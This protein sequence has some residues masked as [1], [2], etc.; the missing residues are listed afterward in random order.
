MQDDDPQILEFI[1]RLGAPVYITGFDASL[2]TCMDI[3]LTLDKITDV[4]N[5]L[6]DAGEAIFWELNYSFRSHGFNCRS[7]FIYTT[8]VSPATD[9]FDFPDLLDK[10]EKIP[11]LQD[12]CCAGVM[13]SPTVSTSWNH[14]T[15]PQSWH[16]VDF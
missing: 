13:D 15:S 1:D 6:P 2:Y 4:H 7:D 16:L 14:S 5:C 11:D 9:S 10:H 8:V 12:G 3:F